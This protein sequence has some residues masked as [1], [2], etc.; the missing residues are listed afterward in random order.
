M[1][2][3]DRADP[4]V[5]PEDPIGGVEVLEAVVA[6]AAPYPFHK[7]VHPADPDGLAGKLALRIPTDPHSLL[8]QGKAAR[9]AVPFPE[10]QMGLVVG[11]LLPGPLQGLAA[12]TPRSRLQQGPTQL[13]PG[14]QLRQ[15]ARPRPGRPVELY[16]LSA[17]WL[18]VLRW[19]P[20][21]FTR[22]QRG[23]GSRSRG[24]G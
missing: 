14:S 16:W 10:F 6:V 3:A 24:R 4:L 7:G 22:Q 17:P 8:G 15:Q 21:A 12:L 5:A 13:A 11:E 19:Q 2:Q 18:L 1:A 23:G 20:M 9:A